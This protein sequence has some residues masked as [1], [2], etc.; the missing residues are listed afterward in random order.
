M[1]K[2]YPLAQL[3][4][5][6]SYPLS[7]WIGLAIVTTTMF[8]APKAT[9][10][11][12]SAEFG[13]V[14]AD[15][16][17][18]P[19]QSCITDPRLKITREGQ[20][21]FDAVLSGEGLCRQDEE[22][23]AVEDLD[24][25]GEPEVILDFS[26][27]GAHCCSSSFIFRYDPQSEQYRSIQH[28]WGEGHG[29]RR[30]QDL[31]EDG[32]PEFIHYDSRFA[33]AFGSFA[34]SGMPIR[35]WQYRAGEM[36]NVTRNYPKQVYDDA[37]K[38]W[39][40]YTEANRQ[41]TDVK[42]VLAAYMADKYL[43][44]EVE[45]GWQRLAQIYQGEDQ[46]QFF[47]K[48]REFLIENGYTTQA[49][50]PRRDPLVR[51]PTESPAPLPPS[52]TSTSEQSSEQPNSVVVLE[53][54]NTL[55]PG[56]AIL[57]IDQTLYD[58]YTFSGQAGQQVVI[59]LESTDFDSYLILVDPN[60][61]IIAENDDAIS[62]SPNSQLTV[63]L[64]QNGMY[65]VIANAYHKEEQGE[66]TLTVTANVIPNQAPSNTQQ[67]PEDVSD[68]ETTETASP[69]NSSEFGTI[70][71]TLFY[72]SEPMPALTVCAQS[73]QNYYL[74]SCIE[75]AAEQQTFRM[76]IRP[77]EYYIFSY[78]AAVLQAG[79][80]GNMQDAFIYYTRSE[81]S[82]DPLPVRV[83]AGRTLSNISP[84]NARVCGTRTPEPAYC[85]KPSS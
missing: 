83:V 14:K 35:I 39:Q 30:R 41:K 37:F 67:P 70:E 76:T 69:T 25:D 78:R 22:V 12:R 34:E 40:L 31:D 71:G 15:Y 85:V 74:L 2:L 1:K 53:E 55:A 36:I 8:L 32:T 72:P 46:Q 60:Q 59:I 73:T 21:V 57:Q 4:L 7:F 82:N 54:Q 18:Q 13:T 5:S 44:N 50:P 45:D 77:G 27:G 84:K 58:E 52:S 23:F 51:R 16:S 33:Y 38:W 28:L 56:D 11:T 24:N 81:T 61:T 62:G 43:L 75:S 9:A 47:A 63:T 49:A 42:G 20:V 65:T 64:P 19:G 29:A 79:R 3:R 26:S 68:D 48:L 80:T 17:E 6:A 10:A 66:Y